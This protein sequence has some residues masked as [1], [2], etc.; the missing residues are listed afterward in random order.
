MIF[1]LND[2][3]L[4]ESV[5]TEEVKKTNALGILLPESA[6]GEKHSHGIVKFV[7]AK[8]TILSDKFK[9]YEVV[10]NKWSVEEFEEDGKKYFI[11]PEDKIIG[12]SGEIEEEKN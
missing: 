6:K 1:P 8:C 12:V 4:L 5:E 2:N 11:I 3:V 10:F 7:G 9:G